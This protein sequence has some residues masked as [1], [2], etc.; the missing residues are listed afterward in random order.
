[1]MKKIILTSFLFCFSV[2][3][4]SGPL[5]IQTNKK[6]FLIHKSKRAF[7]EKKDRPYIK[8]KEAEQPVKNKSIIHKK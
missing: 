8:K 1:M 3:I 4:F 7:I 6:M 5:Q 2:T